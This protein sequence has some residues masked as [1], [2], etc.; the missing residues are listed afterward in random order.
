M[1]S[2]FVLDASALLAVLLDE[3]GT[4]FVSARM[5]ASLISAVNLAE[6]AAKAA[7]YG[8]PLEGLHRTL[9]SLSLTTAPFDDELAY[10]SGSLRAVTRQYGLSLGDRCCLALGLKTNLPVLTTESAW[11][12]LNVGI[13]VE[14]IR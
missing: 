12:K 10:L 9:T 1:S 5:E 8:M 2:R 6:V 14:L 13:E 4:D 11:K 3:P 7:D